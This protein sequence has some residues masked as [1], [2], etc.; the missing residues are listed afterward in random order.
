MSDWN[1]Q[2]IEEF[3]R[4]GGRVGGPFEGANLLL[5]TTA[6][7]RTGR[8]HTTPVVYRRDGDRL[9]VF[10]SNAGRPQHPAWYHNLLANPYVTVEIGTERRRMTAQALEP[11]ERDREYARQAAADPAF[12]AY[13]DGTDRVIPVIA[14]TPDD[15]AHALGEELV[16]I[17]AGLRERLDALLTGADRPSDTVLLENCLTLCQDLHDHHTSE[18]DRGFPLLERRFPG[19]GPVLD[20]LREEHRIVGR[21]REEIVQTR[22]MTRLKELATELVVH[23]DREEQQLIAAL[24]AL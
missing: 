6:G 20:R 8:P 17:H 22:D 5:L 23:F 13:Q 14:L 21:L 9:L 19:I 4:S 1:Q 12:A 15:R 7:A 2:I 24:N 11:A 3:R 10:G 16:R 18:N